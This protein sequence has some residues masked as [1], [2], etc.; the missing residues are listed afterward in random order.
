MMFTSGTE[1]RPKGA[2]LTQPGAAVAVRLLRDRRRH[3]R[4]RRRA[5]HAAA[6]PLR[7]ARLLPRHRRL[8]R[9]HQHHPARARTRPRSC[10]RSRRDRVTKFFAPPT[11]WIGAAARTRSSTTPTCPACAR[12]TTAPRRCRSRCSRRSSER[13][14]DVELWNFYGQ[15]EMAPLATILGPARAARARRLGRPRRAQRRDPDRRRR[16]RA[17]AGRHRRRDRA[18]L[19]RTRRSG[20]YH[21]EAK[22]AEAF[23]GR[24]VPLRR[25]RVRRRG[26]PALRRGPQEGHDQDRRRERRQPRGRGGDLPA[27]RRRRGRGVRDQPPDAGSRR[28]PRSSSP[29]RASTLTS[30]ARHRARPRACWRTTR[31][32]STSSSPTPCPRTRAARSSSAT[33]ARRT[34]TSRRGSH[35]RSSCGEPVVHNSIVRDYPGT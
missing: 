8:P 11:V 22:T 2:L 10:A 6:L 1:S 17:G 26:R 28:S 19:A 3:E 35:G 29:R 14:P 15:T 20:Y 27:R 7:A 12:A 9:R 34:E 18:P 33:C 21:D 16:R 31:R 25:P 24:L 4:R 13:L 32:R 5:A 30:E 23:R